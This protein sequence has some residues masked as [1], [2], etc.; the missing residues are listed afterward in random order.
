MDEARKFDGGKVRTDLLP[1]PAL[2]EVAEVF[3]FGAE[4][5]ADRNYL[6]LEYSRLVGSLLRHVFAWAQGEDDD[7]ETGK[8]HLAHA[9]CN[10]LMLRE[11]QQLGTGTDDR[12]PPAKRGTAEIIVNLEKVLPGDEGAAGWGETR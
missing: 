8:S 3:T 7:P 1:I 2:M 4:K 9:G 10:V 11:M 5:Y 12:W 6:G